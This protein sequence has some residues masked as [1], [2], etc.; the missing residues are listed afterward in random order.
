MNCPWKAPWPPFP[1]FESVKISVWGSGCNSVECWPGFHKSLGLSPA[2]YKIGHG[3]TC[4]KSQPSG[5]KYN[6]EKRSPGNRAF[7][8][9]GRLP[10]R[11]GM[12]PMLKDVK[13]FAPVVD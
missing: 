2:L 10:Q 9:L 3:G 1:C 7:E 6:R 11:G 12:E 8:M 4:L 13:I 5:G